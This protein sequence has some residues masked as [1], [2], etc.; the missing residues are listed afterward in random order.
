MKNNSYAILI[1]LFCFQINAQTSFKKGYYVSSNQDTIYGLIKDYDWKK[2][3][4]EIQFKTS[5]SSIVRSLK[6]E[7]ITF[8]EVLNKVKYKSAKVDI[9]RSDNSISELSKSRLPE[10]KT[11]LVFL[12]V[13]ESGAADL[14][15][16]EQNALIRYF[17]KTKETPI[18]QLIYKRYLETGTKIRENQNFRQQL[19][20]ALKCNDLSINRFKNLKYKE[21][22]LRRVINDYN[23]CLGNTD[24][25]YDNKTSKGTLHLSIRPGVQFASLEVNDNTN[26]SIDAN[27]NNE[28][29][30]RL[31][32]E[33]EIVLPFNHSKW[34]V[35]LE[36]TY[37]NYSSSREF[38]IDDFFPVKRE[39]D[40]A[41]IEV[42][43]SLRYYSFIAP[44]H[45]LFIN[46]GLAYDIG[47]G[48]NEIVG[49]RSRRL[50]LNAQFNPVFG[51]GYQFMQKLAFEFRFQTGRDLLYDY[52]DSSSTFS[53]ASLILGY[54]LF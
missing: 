1:L 36:P 2:N 32:L 4:D 27:F 29:S 19:L 34:S 18:Q 13:L 22:P 3:P 24:Y 48:D 8:F 10:F 41:S 9:D 47:I 7:D 12:K 11:E 31:G 51:I 38:L 26:A 16:F 15:K 6:P 37:Q 23:A 43:F 45:Q 50:D 20:N 28:T 21:K 33:L 49:I 14:Y 35:V 30:F 40:Y 53:S 17:F 39:V 5:A 46:A 42:P 54:K 44:N 52:V 25:S